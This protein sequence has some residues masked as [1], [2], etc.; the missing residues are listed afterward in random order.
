VQARLRTREVEVDDTGAGTLALP[1]GGL[2]W[3]SVLGL[4]ATSTPLQDRVVW[5]VRASPAGRPISDSQNVRI[6]PFGSG[7]GQAGL[8]CPVG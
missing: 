8:L 3:S 4:L 6:G 5:V 2:L 7:H 1:L